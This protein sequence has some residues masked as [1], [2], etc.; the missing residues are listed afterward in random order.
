MR[1]YGGVYHAA[2]VLKHDHI[3]TVPAQF[4]FSL[5]LELWTPSCMKEHPIQFV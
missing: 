1:R 5:H 4:P 3:T 2:T